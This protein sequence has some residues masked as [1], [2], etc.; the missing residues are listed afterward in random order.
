MF[1]CTIVSSNNTLAHKTYFYRDI[2]ITLYS[3]IKTIGP[4]M[5]KSTRIRKNGKEITHKS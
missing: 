3:F 1:C 5:K 4:Y 2:F